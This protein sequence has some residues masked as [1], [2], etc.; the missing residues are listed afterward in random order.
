MLIQISN[1]PLS[2]QMC[3]A[4]LKVSTLGLPVNLGDRMGGRSPDHSAPNDRILKVTRRPPGP[5]CPC[6]SHR[7]FQ[8]RFCNFPF[9][10]VLIS[11]LLCVFLSKFYFTP[12]KEPNSSARLV[13]EHLNHSLP[14]SISSSRRQTLSTLWAD[15]FGIY[16][17]IIK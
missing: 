13:M 16:F 12:F 11:L 9:D 5:G 2:I 7:A 10:P 8:E 14:T 3:P 17:L 15:S 6:P 1:A 4:S